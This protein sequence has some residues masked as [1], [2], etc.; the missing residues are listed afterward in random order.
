MGVHA[1]QIYSYVSTSS[2]L[3]KELVGNNWVHVFIKKCFGTSQD[4]CFSLLHASNNIKELKKIHAHILVNGF[5]QDILLETKLVQM[6]S[7]NGSLESARLVFDR[8]SVRNVVIWNVLIRGYVRNGLCEDAMALYSQMLLDGIRPDKFTFPCVLNACTGLLALQNGKEVHEHLIRSGLESDVYVASALVDMHAKCGRLQDARQVF[9]KMPQRDVALWN[10]L[11]GAYVHNGFCEEALRIFPEIEVTGEK[12]D[13]GTVTSVLPACSRLGALWEGRQVHGF[14]LRNGFEDDVFVGS[15]LVDMY[16][17]CGSVDTA[18]LVFDKMTKR[19]SVSWNS[20]IVGYFYND[21]YDKSVE[22]FRQMQLTG[23]T[24][25]S[26]SI[27]CVLSAC[28]VLANLQV[29]KEIHGYLIRT[30]FDT[31]S[32][33]N[34]LMDMYAKCKHTEGAFQVFKNMLLRDIVSW[35]TMIAGYSQNGLSEEALNLFCEIQFEGIKPD[36]D[37]V[38]SVL[39]ACAQSGALQQGREIHGYAIR[40]GL[41]TDFVVCGLID[42]YAKCGSIDVANRVFIKMS[43]KNMVQWSAMISG[44]AQNGY[45]EE[46][47]KLFCRMQMTGVNPDSVAIVS[48]ISACAGLAALGKGK[49]IHSYVL[50]NRFEGN[51]VV[52]N[53]LIDMYAKCGSIQSANQVFGMMS[54]RNVVSWN[55]MIAGHGTHGQAEDA[56]S[57]FKKLQELGVKPDGITFVA[58]LSACSH[59]GLVDEGWQYFNCMSQD[60]HILPTMEHYACM[61]DILGRAGC[62]KE[63]LDFIKMMPIK[64]NSGV[65]GAL[66]G[67]CRNHHNVEL[68]EHVV[69]HLF[70]L[71]SENSGTYALLSNIYAASGRWDD[72]AHV[73]TMMKDLRVKK[74]PGCSW[75]EVKNQVHAF[76][77]GEGP[78]YR[79]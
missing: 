43:K 73:R 34:A 1:R 35:C 54:Q 72:K 22:L 16:A 37:T 60:H 31:I 33:K 45:M 10:A 15:A 24:L 19:N 38:A 61:V 48:A 39:P 36:T 77:V 26:T 56:I 13:S 74:M 8:V 2:I 76:I 18:R 29:G 79:L 12:P 17:K 78:T 32:T 41:E 3:R 27:S 5:E 64:A 59:S 7:L 50:R 9:D 6:Y 42:M 75:I 40:S 53:G 44:Y 21:Y 14:I 68:G 52:G 62:L 70:K 63:A 20:L 58:L 23:V 71:K 55:V 4:N 57:L 47:L 69:D 51:I 65:W 67:A 25:D 49:E 30:E 11:I 46:T 28:A 66:F